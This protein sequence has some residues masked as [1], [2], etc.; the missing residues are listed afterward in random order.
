L[1]ARD[2]S[3]GQETKLKRKLP[4]SPAWTWRLWRSK[5]PWEIQILSTTRGIKRAEAV[6]P[7]TGKAFFI[8]RMSS[9]QSWGCRRDWLREDVRK[10][11]S[12]RYLGI[13]LLPSPTLHHPKPK[14]C[15]SLSS[16][17]RNVHPLRS[18]LRFLP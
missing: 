17:G 18:I 5:I 15:H 16:L 2:T 10:N 3:R 9:C 14:S 4:C 7:M 8:W 1:L 11:L 13:I 6:S 12:T